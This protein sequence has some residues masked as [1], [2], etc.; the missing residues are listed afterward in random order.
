MPKTL[1][2]ELPDE[3]YDALQKLSQEFGISAEQLASEWL[4][5]QI[6]QVIN[7]PLAKWIGAIEMPPWADRHDELLGEAILREMKGEE[8]DEGD[9]R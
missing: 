8:N 3:A 2:I 6:Q 1:T 9:F 5:K 7:D 4:T